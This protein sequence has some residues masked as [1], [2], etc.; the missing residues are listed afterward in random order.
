MSTEMSTQSNSNLYEIKEK[1]AS[2]EEALISEHPQIPTILRDI[3]KKLKADE[4]CVT[5]LSE[6]ECGTIV[7]GLKKQTSTE[8]ATKA[9]KKAKTKTKKALSKI[10]L[11]DL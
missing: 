7:R 3:H 9:V 5:L 11:D 10:T 4:E 8:I 1:I 2:L 6:E